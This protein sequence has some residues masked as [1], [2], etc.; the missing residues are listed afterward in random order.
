MCVCVCVCACFTIRG[1]HEVDE[2]DNTGIIG[3]TE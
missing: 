3:L 1:F 2:I